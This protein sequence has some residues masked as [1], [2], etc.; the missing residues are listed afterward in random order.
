MPTNISGR[1]TKPMPYLPPEIWV[2]VFRSLANSQDFAGIWNNGRRTSH[3][4]KILIESV[5]RI[6]VVPAMVANL[7]LIGCT[8][9]AG[10]ER[11]LLE[12]QGLCD[13][14][15]RACFGEKGRASSSILPGTGGPTSQGKESRRGLSANE[16]SNIIPPPSLPCSPPVLIEWASHFCVSVARGPTRFVGNHGTEKPAHAWFEPGV[17]PPTMEMRVDH[18]AKEVSFRWKCLL[19]NLAASL[20]NHPVSPG[21]EV[22]P[23]CVEQ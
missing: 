8:A 22:C 17:A 3:Y 1:F 2:T 23:L 18:G 5:F 14:G 10:A 13:D 21:P 11:V 12:F 15:E 7:S 16:F 6:N 9:R 20:N 19:S 4:F